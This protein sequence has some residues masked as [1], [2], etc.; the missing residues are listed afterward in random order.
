MEDRLAVAAERSA[1]G[2]GLLGDC[3]S[4]AVNLAVDLFRWVD[5]GLQAPTTSAG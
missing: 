4:D 2:G 3:A 5:V 1:A